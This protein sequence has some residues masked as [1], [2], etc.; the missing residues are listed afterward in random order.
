VCKVHRLVKEGTVGS[1]LEEEVT[2]RVVEG[3]WPWSALCLL[4]TR[5]QTGTKSS[6][7]PC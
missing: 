6:R 7:L 5:S 1:Y 3:K 4:L 2:R